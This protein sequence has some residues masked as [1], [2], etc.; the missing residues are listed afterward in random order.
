[1]S[2]KQANITVP[3]D[4]TN[5]GQFFACCGLLELADRLWPGVLVQANSGELEGTA[6][7][8]DERI[9]DPCA[10]QP[11]ARIGG[12]WE[13]LK[14]VTTDAGHTATFASRVVSEHDALAETE[15]NAKR[16]H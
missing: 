1:M 3:V 5:P 12:P 10:I 11:E 14:S 13:I 16:P 2:D 9:K 8:Y 4:V 7:T 15:F 6:S